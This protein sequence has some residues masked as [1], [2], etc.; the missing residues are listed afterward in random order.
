[1]SPTQSALI[2]RVPEADEAVGPHRAS[3]DTAASWGVLAHVTVLYPFLPPGRIDD[4]VLARVAGAVARVP[5]FAMTL[6]SVR[7][8]D[9]AV[10]WLAPE[11]AEPFRAL[12]AAV[13]ERFPETPPYGGAHPD[14]A[15]HL[16]IGHDAPRHLLERAAEAVAAHL[17]IRTSVDAV[18]LV[19]GSPEADSWHAVAG[20]PL[21]NGARPGRTHREL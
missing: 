9:D 8:F 6:R 5:R 11:P 21:G 15:P 3:L 4:E 12:T 14:S 13:W 18:S 2:V 16:T 17:P 20:F 7:W 19:V 1:M 10:V